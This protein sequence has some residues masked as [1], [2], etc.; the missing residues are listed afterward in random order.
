MED[1][2]KENTGVL[3]GQRDTD[4]IAG[5]LP[6][7]VRNEKGDWRPH[8]VKEEKQYSENVDTMGC[9]SFSMNNC[10]EIQHKHQ[11]G[12]EVNFSD[13]FLAKMSETTP[14]GNYL[15][16]VADAVRKYGLITEEQ[17]PTPPAY[18]W[19][20]YY[21]DIPQEVKDKAQKMEMGYEWITPSK[22][23]LLYHLKH[24][25]IQIVIPEPHPNH[26][27]VLVAIEG[28]K[29]FYFDTYAP[30]LKSISVS[31]INSA[32]KPVLTMQNEFV[33]TINIKGAIGLVILADTVENLKF[34][35]KSYNK[36]ITVNPDGTIPT[37]YRID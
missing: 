34:L 14:Q 3:I 23:D 13:R 16:K 25:P 26:A 29:A 36:T 12:E 5:I 15:Y 28:D 7:E 19:A 32:L 4:F 18:T 22:N 1:I 31:K 20:S 2:P 9:V 8:L 33:K 35:A 11:T 10:L 30:Y 24:A 21:A 27:V 6:Y 17:W 37:E